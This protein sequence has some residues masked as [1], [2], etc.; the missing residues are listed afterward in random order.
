MCSLV[1][2]NGRRSGDY[3]CVDIGSC[4]LQIINRYI[5]PHFPC[6][7]LFILNHFS[8]CLSYRITVTPQLS[9]CSSW[10]CF[11]FS[12]YTC[13]IRYS[14]CQV[15]CGHEV[16]HC[17]E[18]NESTHFRKSFSVSTNFLVSNVWLCYVGVMATQHMD[19]LQRRM[20]S[21]YVPS[22]VC[23]TLVL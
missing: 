9:T 1:S 6:A 12:L 21:W 16:L 8:T 7:S 19:G 15:L 5:G 3:T 10:L 11:N 13:V 20:Y 4:A 23:L 18:L 14:E 2:G 17:F 22:I